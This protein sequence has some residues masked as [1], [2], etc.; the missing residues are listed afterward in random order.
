[1]IPLVALAF[2]QPW[3]VLIAT[4]IV[5]AAEALRLLLWQSTV[6]HEIDENVSPALSRARLSSLLREGGPDHPCTMTGAWP[7]RS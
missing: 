3:L 1:M 6:A 7:R 2:W 5:L 4:G